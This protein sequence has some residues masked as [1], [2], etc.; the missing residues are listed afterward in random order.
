MKI[1]AVEERPGNALAIVLD[2]ARIAA[3]VAL[4]VAEIPARAR[5]QTGYTRFVNG[6]DSAQYA[7]QVV[8]ESRR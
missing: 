3:A 7:D 5:V 1:D 2:L 8:A 6:E 4:W